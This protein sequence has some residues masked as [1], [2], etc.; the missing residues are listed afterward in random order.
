MS[1]SGVKSLE[2]GA[3]HARLPTLDSRPSAFRPKPQAPSPKHQAPST[4]HQAPSTKHQAPST[5][6]QAP[7]TK[8][9][10]PSQ[11]SSP[12]KKGATSRSFLVNQLKVVL[13]I[14]K[15]FA[16]F[17]FHFIQRNTWCYFRS[18]TA[19]FT[20]FL[21]T[22]ALALCVVSKTSTCWD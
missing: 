11:L 7:S 13:L 17:S 19:Q 9:Q 18:V 1:Q 2:S 20:V 21:I 22:L 15:R 6:H 12:I 14:A 16:E 10:A 4:K 8:H 3:D 5:K